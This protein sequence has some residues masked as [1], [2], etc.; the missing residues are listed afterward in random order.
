L[1]ISLFLPFSCNKD[2]SLVRNEQIQEVNLNEFF[3]ASQVHDDYLKIFIKENLKPSESF[4]YINQAVNSKGGSNEELGLTEEEFIEFLERFGNFDY[5]KY[6]EQHLMDEII[7]YIMKVKM[8]EIILLFEN[9]INEK[10]HITLEEILPIILEKE[11]EYYN[12]NYLTTDEKNFLLS[13][14]VVCRAS[15]E[16]WSENIEDNYSTR[17]KWWQ[18]VLGVAVAD[19]VGVGVGFLSTGSWFVGGILGAAV[20][21]EAAYNLIHY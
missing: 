3:F 15:L 1:A 2:A 7:N 16:F 5:S 20:S 10:E 13:C 4:N 14:S 12:S 19:A 11:E 6:I 18:I 17:R 9:E 8:D 21:A